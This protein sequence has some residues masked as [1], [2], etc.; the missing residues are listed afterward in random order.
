[1]AV[2]AP[3]VEFVPVGLPSPAGPM[4]VQVFSACTLV[5]SIT[6]IWKLTVEGTW[7]RPSFSTGWPI[8]IDQSLSWPVAVGE[9][10]ELAICKIYSAFA[11]RPSSELSVTVLPLG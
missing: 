1:M 11:E 8:E 7:P 3:A 9:D 6:K 5:G 2:T 4:A 10:D